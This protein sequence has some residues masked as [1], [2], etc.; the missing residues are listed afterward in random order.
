MLVF[1]K[2]QSQY[3]TSLKRPLCVKYSRPCTRYHFEHKC[4]FVVCYVRRYFYVPIENQ[5]GPINISRFSFKISQQYQKYRFLL[6]L[7]NR[8]TNRFTFSVDLFVVCYGSRK[9]Q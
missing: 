3:T 9:L 8:K 4:M 1:G 7:T 2:V 5:N 6:G